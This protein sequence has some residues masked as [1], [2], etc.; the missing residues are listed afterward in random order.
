MGKEVNKMEFIGI[1]LL[2]SLFVCMGF[3]VYHKTKIGKIDKVLKD[4]AESMRRLKERLKEE[5]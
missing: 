3:F 5:E 4:V 2:I 1:I